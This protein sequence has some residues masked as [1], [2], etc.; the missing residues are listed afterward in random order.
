MRERV[1]AVT[2]GS[3]VALVGV[4]D[5]VSDAQVEFFR[6]AVSD[7]ESRGLR[8]LVV[9]LEP[10]PVATLRG[11]RARP[12]FQDIEYRLWF[13]SQCGV[14]SRIVVG[15]TRQEVEEEGASFLLDAL[16]KHVRIDELLLRPGQSL[17]RGVGGSLSTIQECGRRMGM[18]VGVSNGYVGPVHIGEARGHM[19]KGELA[20]A[21]ALLSQMFYCARPSSGERTLPWPPGAYIA[22]PVEEPVSGEVQGRAPVE[23]TLTPCNDGSL[24]QWPKGAGRWLAFAAGP[25]DHRRSNSGWEAGDD[26][27]RAR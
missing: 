9:T 11:L 27:H 17:G 6:D 21:G 8:V 22:W 3:H 1:V 4:W 14:Q 12:A 5:P 15:L 19:V 26:L 13:Q 10:D 16:R 2:P 24:L 20:R 7:A 23:I 18:R 25:G